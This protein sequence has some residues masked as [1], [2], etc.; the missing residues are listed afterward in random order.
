MINNL[1][2]QRTFQNAKNPPLTNPVHAPCHICKGTIHPQIPNSDSTWLEIT[3]V[4]FVKPT[5]PISEKTM[6]PHSNTLA[7]KI[8]WT[9]EPGGLQSMELQRVRHDRAT[10]LSIFTLMHWKRKWQPTPVFLPGESQGRGSLMGCRLWGHA[11]SDTTEVT[12]QQ[13]QQSKFQ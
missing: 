6:A 9:E 10:S 13:Q 4:C 5:L 8:P 7:W 12:Q 3:R 2:E 1:G 11:E